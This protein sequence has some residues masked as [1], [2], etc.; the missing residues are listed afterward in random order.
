[1]RLLLTTILLF[2]AYIATSQVNFGCLTLDFE[3]IP[4]GIPQSGA[5][6]S[7][8]Y[9]ESFGVTFTLEGGGNPVLAD[10]GGAQEA[11][12]SAW[13]SNDIPAPGV[14]IGNF[15]LTDDGVLQ[16]L[17]SPP[18][19]LTFDIPID[20]F[21][22]CILDIDF[23]ETFLIEAMDENGDVILRET[24]TEGDPDTGDGALTCWGFNLP[25]CEGSIY[26][27]RYSGSR[28]MAGAF[29]LGMDNFS[30]CYT[31]APLDV[32][33]IPETCNQLGSIEVIDTRDDSYEFSL[34]NESFTSNGRFED[35]PAGTYPVFVRDSEGCVAEI[36][37]F[38]IEYV[39]PEIEEV[40]V[41]HTS[42]GDTNGQLEVAAG[43]S[44]GPL[45]SIDEVNYQESNVF[46]SLPPGLYTVFVKDSFDC[47]TLEQAVIDPSEEPF[48]LGIE[49]MNDR[50]D[51]GTGFIN[52]MAEGTEIVFSLNEEEMESNSF[53]NLS[54]GDYVV[55]ITDVN[56]CTKDELVQ[57]R[58]SEETQLLGVD[59]SEPNCG[60]NDGSIVLDLSQ[61]DGTPTI[62]LKDTLDAF[63]ELENLRPG[64][65]TLRLVDEDGC[66]V[67]RE[68][69]LKMPS[70]GMAISMVSLL[71]KMYIPTL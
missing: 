22:G 12:G 41:A 53:E 21:A 35:L 26:S 18:I 52:V 33:N 71:S 28:D 3:S 65:Y 4:G 5:I 54:V 42:C 51:E 34:D 45:Y 55:R 62:E 15:F 66:L 64:A 2:L 32:V 47:L 25:G 20:T 16:G 60:S 7:D 13:G 57:I 10:V 43:Q 56:G 38:V 49:K 9:K 27:I 68:I 58:L 48:I 30:F 6:L 46:D 23:G 63:N 11:F 67:R 19:V 59:I 1:M 36:P 14:D 69:I 8:Q 29:G 39:I 50:C 37:A 40:G 17:T 24:I 44:R 31:A 61:I 70:S